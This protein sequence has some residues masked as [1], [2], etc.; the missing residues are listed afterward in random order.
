MPPCNIRAAKR[1]PTLRQM[2]SSSSLSNDDDAVNAAQVMVQRTESMSSR[3]NNRA[4]LTREELDNVINSL[5]NITPRP[6]DDDANNEN[7]ID[8][9][10]LEGVLSD[11][12]HISHKDWHVTDINSERLANVLLR[13]RSSDDDNGEGGLLNNC[14]QSQ[15]MFE[16]ILHEGN[17]DGALSHAAANAMMN[18]TGDNKKKH[19]PWAVLVTGVNG[20]RKTSSIYQPWFSKVLMEALVSP[21]SLLSSSNKEGANDVSLEMLPNGHN[22]FFRQ[23]DHIIATLCNEDF[24]ILY[25]LT[26]AQLLLSENNNKPLVNDDNNNNQPPKDLIEKYS[27]LKGSIF[28]R[29][30]TIS[31][32]LGVILLKEAQ[33][34]NLNIM[35]ETSGR[36]ISM[37]HYIDHFFS[38]EQ[39][40]KLALH[41]TIND[42]S[43]AMD[44][45]DAR[46]VHEMKIG[47]M[48][49]ESEDVVEV[50]YANAGGPYGS[51]VLRG[52]QV[53]SDRVWEEVVTSR[54]DD[55]GGVGGGWYLAT[56]R[57]NAS[58]EKP[59]TI[60]ALRPDGKYGT[61]YTFGEPRL[62]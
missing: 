13:L 53:D 50:I 35:C 57:I 56:M 30:R 12:A 25:A 29:Y 2:M 59:W 32:L 43:H 58:T 45:V 21:S 22:S 28:S 55:G 4:P 15:Q 16:R 7:N 48:A 62:V 38:D 9:V 54:G 34:S 47:K 44:S 27:N 24:S 26:A 49:V 5:R 61:E 33:Q 42:L 18:T 11:I 10:A 60:Q 14:S 23:L 36:D 19:K 31:E 51:E 17:W 52:V 8:W 1:A 37:F 3:A 6:R 40:N 46:M 20:I 41:F 39:Y